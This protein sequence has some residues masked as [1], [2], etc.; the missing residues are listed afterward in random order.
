LQKN[1]LANKS[2][3]IIFSDCNKNN[4][5]KLEVQNVRT[6]LKLIDGFKS[7]TVHESPIN[8]GLA[9]S[10]IG[11]ITTVF[12]TYD[13]VI[14][15]EDDLVT[16]PNFLDF[17]NESLEMFKNDSSVFSISGFSFNLN[18]ENKLK[19][20]AYF[21][22]R[23]WSWGWATWKNR[24][25]DLDWE[26]LN[27]KDFKRDKKAQ[28]EF[29]K[30]G[31]DLNR[32]LAKQISGKLDSWAIRW[33]YNQFK[34]KGLTLYPVYSKIKNEGFGKNATHTGGS[35]KRYIPQFDEKANVNFNYPTQI[36]LTTIAQK[37]FNQKMGIIARIK[38]KIETILGL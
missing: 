16:S 35:S 7:V 28:K 15:L 34:R 37:R 5:D 33:F 29:S 25:A 22:N 8:K 14:V 31:S 9:N 17:M 36:E 20:D 32:M 10:I 1:Y 11:G 26:V 27:Y 2:D 38:S 6:Y 18:L 24:W 13:K 19:T 21:L 4:F 23:G 30:G 12:E 3:L